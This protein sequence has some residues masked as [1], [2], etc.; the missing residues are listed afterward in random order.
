M[1]A[2][3]IISQFLLYICL[4][5][6]MGTFLLT[7]IPNSIRPNTAIAPRWLFVSGVAIP[8][9]SFIPN[10]QLL[11]ILMPQ[12]GFLESLKMLLTNF[13]VGH[14]WLAIVLLSGILLIVIRFYSKRSS[15]LNAIMAMFVL[16]AIMAAIGY[17]SHAGSMS[18]IVGSVFDF[19]HLV[20]VS[21][22]LGILILISFFSEDAENWEA[23]LKWFSPVALVSLTTIALSGVLMTETIVPKYVTSWASDYGQFFF[24]KHVL[25]VPLT[26]IILANALLIKLKINKP[27]FEPRTWVKIETVLLILI[28]FITALYSEQQPPNFTVQEISPFFELF[29]NRTVETGMRAY[30]QMTGI[31]VAFFLLTAVFI[32]LV[33]VSYIKQFPLILTISMLLAI[34]VCFYL[35]FM[36]IVFF[37]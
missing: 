18:G 12:F 10:V 34:A 33:V 24:I 1:I 8:I 26:T 37:R 30:L 14:S 16:I 36:S 13:K 9:V 19:L 27:F 21:V 5:V 2:F 11:V 17:I 22:W 29:Y 28:L 32:G 3:S 7:C 20:A 6:L 35:G 25:L 4:A 23:F 31:S 15:K